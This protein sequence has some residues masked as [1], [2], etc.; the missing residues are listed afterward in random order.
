MIFKKYTENILLYF[1]RNKLFMV[2]CFLI[3]YD[4]FF[5]K[6]KPEI[7]IIYR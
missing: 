3:I 7:N 5:N 6:K 2:I 1:Y 4:D